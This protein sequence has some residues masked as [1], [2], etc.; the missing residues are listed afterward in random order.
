M[1]KNVFV[2]FDVDGTMVLYDTIETHLSVFRDAVAEVSGK[3]CSYPGDLLGYDIDGMM[4]R[5]I[6]SLM[7]EK[8]ETPVTQENID[9]VEEIMQRL[10]RERMT[11]K[12]S[13][14]KGVERVLKTLN[15]MPNT[16]I[17]VASGNLPGIAWKKLENAGLSRYF[18][19]RIGGFGVV[20]D[21]KAAVRRAREMAEE[22]TGKKYDVVVH[23]GDTRADVEAAQANGAKAVGVRTGSRKE[24]DYPEPC[25]VINDMEEGFNQLMAYLQ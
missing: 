11:A 25:L 3:P 6:L 1:T 20:E 17:G 4:D 7:L 13:V 12:A 2:S 18:P 24:W 8:L 10:F 21:R 15:D 23:I 5:R 9:K 22:V 14:P 19:D 16:T